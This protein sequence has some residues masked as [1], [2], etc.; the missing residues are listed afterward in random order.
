MLFKVLLYNYHLL[1]T[2]NLIKLGYRE[3]YKHDLNELHMEAHEM[4]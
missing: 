3:N 1:A 4:L 2:L